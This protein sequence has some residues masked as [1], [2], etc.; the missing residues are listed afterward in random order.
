[1]KK[2]RSLE[3]QVK[4]GV[5]EMERGYF[6]VSQDMQKLMSD[7]RILHVQD[8]T[9]V[10]PAS[11]DPRI[12]DEAFILDVE[13]GM[14]RP[15]ERET[16]YRTLLQIPQSKRQRV[17]L[18]NGFEINRGYTYLIPL[19][20]RVF[21]QQGEYMRSSP[22][23]TMGRVFIR[24]RMLGD[25]N[26]AFNEIVGGKVASPQQL[27]LLVQPLQFNE[28]IYPGISFNQLRFFHG[29]GARLNDAEI[30]EEWKKNP[31]VFRRNEDDT[32]AP[33]EPIVTDGVRIHLDLTGR[34]TKGVVGLRARNTPVPI[35]FGKENFYR[36]EDYFEPLFSKQ[37]KI[38]IIGPERYLFASKEVLGIPLHLSAE[39]VSHSDL[40]F[41]GEVDLAGFV[42]PWFH[43]DLVS[44]VIP[45]EQ[46]AI[47]IE[48]GI[49]FSTLDI[50]RSKNGKKA[51]VKYGEGSGAHYQWQFGPRT[52]KFFKP[53]DFEMATKSYDKL[54]R[55]VLVQDAKIL[56]QHRK[57]REGFEFLDN[58]QALHLYRDVSKGFFQSRYDCES[59]EL[60]LQPIPY[61]I[62]FGPGGM[63]F[64]YVRASDIKD[65]GDARLFGKHSIGV[66]GHIKP[67]DGPRFIQKC[68]ERELGEEVASLEGSAEPRFMG[69]LMAYRTPVD[70]VHFGLIY[71]IHT[72]GDIQPKESSFHSGRMMPIHKLL[73]EKKIN[74]RYETWSSMLI[75]YLHDI[76]AR[77]L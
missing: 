36:A 60:I 76:Y 14:F 66:G 18:S 62:L 11:L 8:P 28:I 10:K 64:S 52:A 58:S 1:M 77:S 44:E 46:S 70:R 75:P 16:V 13:E 33:L 17:S 49:P 40:G 24:T 35:D 27:W 74:D 42:D 19:E 56:Q 9:Q 38:K 63:V 39:L 31:F 25:Y 12:G 23:S 51:G 57:E 43:G 59:D 6:L 2:R 41:V 4:K 3:S 15:N 50:C 29:S 20:E 45:D 72:Q 55:L 67:E 22:K 69:T 68:I 71:A 61:I 53:F 26:T 37:G 34:K 73:R 7:G 65:Y 48:D 5:K 54:S 32:L 47:E 21:L 30:V